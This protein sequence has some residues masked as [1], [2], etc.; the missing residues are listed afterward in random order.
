MRNLLFMSVIGLAVSLAAPTS[1]HI[2]SECHPHLREFLKLRQEK[3]DMQKK[4]VET[5]IEILEDRKDLVFDRI[6][7]YINVG[8]R[9]QPR[10]KAAI[11]SLEESDITIEVLSKKILEN[12]H[13]MEDRIT[14]L[15]DS[16]IRIHAFDRTGPTA[17]LT[18]WMTCLKEFEYTSDPRHGDWPPGYEEMPLLLEDIRAFKTK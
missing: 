4:V 17:A 10:L 9:I 2:P 3:W 16:H 6:Q 18:K 11:P 7:D 8:G 1:A 14:E 15:L 5:H 12:E 13:Q